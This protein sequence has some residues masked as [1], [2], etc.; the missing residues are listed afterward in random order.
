LFFAAGDLVSIVPAIRACRDPQ[1]DN[2]R[3][4]AVGGE[5][6]VII[7]GDADLLALHPFRGVE[8]MTPAVFSVAASL[9]RRPPISVRIR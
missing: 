6:G 9:T 7:T 3:K 4:F 8:I 1:D 2:F 5:A